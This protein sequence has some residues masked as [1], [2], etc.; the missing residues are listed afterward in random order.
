M[1]LYDTVWSFILHYNRY[2]T[3][4]I[5]NDFVHWFL[6][7]MLQSNQTYQ[8]EA[9]SLN[10]KMSY[11][12]KEFVYFHCWIFYCI[13]IIWSNLPS[14]IVICNYFLTFATWTISNSQCFVVRPWN[15][16][17][18]FNW[19][20]PFTWS[21]W[22]TRFFRHLSVFRSMIRIWIASCSCAESFLPAILS[23]W[24]NF[25][26]CGFKRRIS[27]DMTSFKFSEFTTVLN[28]SFFP[29]LWS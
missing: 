24:S 4:K 22:T 17:H 8:R 18:S 16:C 26:R 20:A 7:P 13:K 15:I 5:G 14:C 21:V 3:K 28:F 6:L 23:T 12:L 2:P 29:L 25:H 10:D 19:D 9:T 11:R 1:Q 27:G